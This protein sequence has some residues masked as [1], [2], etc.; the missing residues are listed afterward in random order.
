M[1]AEAVLYLLVGLPASGKTTRARD[2][3][4]THNALRFTPD[5][6]MIPLYG[7]SD[8]GGKRDVLE[9]RLIWV[10]LRAMQAGIS[11]VLDF[12]FWGRD[13][14]SA[15]V[16]LAE[17]LGAHASVV[18]LAVDEATQRERIAARFMTAPETTFAI[19]ADELAGWRAFFQVPTDDELA[20]TFRPP[21]PAGY[22]TWSDWASVRWPSLPP[23][24]DI[25]V[26]SSL[27]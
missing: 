16:W 10:A 7:E 20:G 5:E 19:S 14:R 25:R 15:L 11:A 17:T 1:V 22:D 9:G 13:E 26:V 18:Y 3:E 21:A 8:P 23:L 12:G 4:R 6:W 27:T 2:L 24:D